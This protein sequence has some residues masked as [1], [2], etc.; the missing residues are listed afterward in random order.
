MRGNEKV[1]QEEGAARAACA[2]AAAISLVTGSA[3]SVSLHARTHAV[4]LD[5]RV[6]KDHSRY[7]LALS[8]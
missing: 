6:R 2:K 1:R 5:T 3:G 7:R 8:L 4:N